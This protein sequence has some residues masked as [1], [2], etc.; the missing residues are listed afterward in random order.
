M[1]VSQR[2]RRHNYSWP[3]TCTSTDARFVA[4]LARGG[5]EG[6]G[7]AGGPADRRALVGG[8]PDGGGQAGGAPA[9]T[10]MPTYG[11]GTEPLA[12]SSELRPFCNL[13]TWVE[14]VLASSCESVCRLITRAVGA[15]RDPRRAPGRNYREV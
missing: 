4:A 5:P 6:G 15:G 14:Y 7:P 11:G 2:Q 3:R 12:P 13:F 10:E 8:G 1:S 9:G